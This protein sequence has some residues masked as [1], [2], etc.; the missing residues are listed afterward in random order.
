MH[1]SL[2]TLTIQRQ[3]GLF[4][5][6]LVVGLYATVHTWVKLACLP[7]VGDVS[8]RRLISM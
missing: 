8:Q 2:D 3:S 4:R 7:R 1:V 5:T 6:L